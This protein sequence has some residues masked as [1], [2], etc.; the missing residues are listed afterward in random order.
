MDVRVT[1]CFRVIKVLNRNAYNT[2]IQKFQVGRSRSKLLVSSKF[3]T[4][5]IPKIQKFQGGPS[6]D[7]LI[8]SLKFTPT[9][10]QTYRNFRVDFRDNKLIVSLQFTAHTLQKYRN[11]RVDL[12]VTNLWYP[13]SSQ[14]LQ[15]K[16]TENSGW[17]FGLQTCSV[18]KVHNATMQ[19]FSG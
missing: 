17:T 8:V 14:R 9:T 6:R 12:L 19:T 1:I 16:D 11:F 15:S 2:K 13:E 5:T 10:I 7:K 4:P 3:T 18:R